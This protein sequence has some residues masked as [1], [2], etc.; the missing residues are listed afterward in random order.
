MVEWKVIEAKEYYIIFFKEN[1][2]YTG[3]YLFKRSMVAIMAA[4]FVLNILLKYPLMS[5]ELAKKLRGTNV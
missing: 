3:M 2:L 1:R 4:S 5:D